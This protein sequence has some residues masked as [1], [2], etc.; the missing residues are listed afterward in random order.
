MDREIWEA[1]RMSVKRVCRSFKFFG[2]KP[3]FSHQQ[4]MLMYFW[5]VWQGGCL[6]WACNRIHYGVLFRPRHLPS[7]SQFRRR[8]SEEVFQSL[9]LKIHLDLARVGF[10]S[11][12][13]YLDGKP[14]LV[15]PVSKDPE[16]PKRSYH[17]RLWQRIQAARDDQRKPPHCDLERHAAERC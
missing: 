13:K 16:R 12:V 2:R 5:S 9:L 3:T 7:V 8:V 14:Q 4:I 6:N 10:S 17:W 1:L 11:P 15:S